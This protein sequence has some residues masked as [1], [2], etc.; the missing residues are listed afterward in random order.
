MQHQPRTSRLHRPVAAPSTM[1]GAAPV[2]VDASVAG[3]VL[4]GRYRIGECIGSGAMA[5]RFATFTP[6]PLASSSC[7]VT[8][9]PGRTR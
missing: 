9:I 7:G 2:P 4:G 8:G 6:S 5:Q 3:T 1:H